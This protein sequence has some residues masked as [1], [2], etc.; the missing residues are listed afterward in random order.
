MTRL[1]PLLLSFLFHACLTADRDGFDTGTP[2]GFLLFSQLLPPVATVSDPLFVAVAQGGKLY[3]SRDGQTWNPASSPVAYNL[4]AVTYCNGM[5]VAVGGSASPGVIYSRDGETWQVANIS[6]L[7][8][9][10]SVACLG[11]R[12]VAAQSGDD[13]MHYS[14]GGVDWGPDDITTSLSPITS[15]GA[16]NGH[17]MVTDTTGFGAYSS[18]GINWSASLAMD[19]GGSNISK[20]AYLDSRFVAIS[21]GSGSGNLV[22]ATNP[23]GPWTAVQA[24]GPG[25]RQAIGHGQGRYLVADDSA[26]IYT[27]ADLSV[28]DGPYASG[29]SD[30]V[31][32]A[33]GQGKFVVG[34]DAGGSNAFLA[35]STD[36]GQTWTDSGT[37]GA[38][39]V[40]S[41]VFRP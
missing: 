20:I 37:A 35:W 26:Q 24:G 31:A 12:F 15:I 33:Y 3:T 18:D 23:A 25:V 1:L 17:Y 19:A 41:I 29:A 27:S 39:V 36:G 40:N 30:P 6:G 16:G 10:G 22:Y 28:W 2:R 38:G 34:G 11:S 4:E 14:D 9:L 13:Y 7:A 8:A 21:D 32:F 5:F